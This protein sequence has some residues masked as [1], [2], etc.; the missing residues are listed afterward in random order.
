[1]HVGAGTGYYSAVLAE[2]VGREGR[3]TA[4]EIDP[5]L[6]G[7]ARRNLAPGWPQAAVVAAD[8]FAFR[9]DRPADAI[10]VNAGVSHLSP[11]WLDALAAAG[12]PAGLGWPLRRRGALPRHV[13]PNG[14]LRP[15]GRKLLERKGRSVA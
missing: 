10:V 2:I 1:V 11:A 6:A 7:R 12:R 5:S 13:G 4:V 9:P 15:D 14:E 8:G 3:V